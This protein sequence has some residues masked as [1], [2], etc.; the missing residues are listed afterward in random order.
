M[1]STYFFGLSGFRSGVLKVLFSFQKACHLGSTSSKG[2]VAGGLTGVAVAESDAVSLLIRRREEVVSR[3]APT[4]AGGGRRRTTKVLD[5]KAAAE[6]KLKNAI[7]TLIEMIDRVKDLSDDIVSMIFLSS[8][9]E[10]GRSKKEGMR[11]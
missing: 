2:Y 4:V 9:L 3:V 5:E 8:S 10:M 6:R 7:I 1:S 11:F